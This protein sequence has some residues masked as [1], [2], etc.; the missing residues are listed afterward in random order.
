LLHPTGR[1]YVVNT[2]NMKP[3]LCEYLTAVNFVIAQCGG[4]ANVSA[5]PVAGLAHRVDTACPASRTTCLHSSRRS[6]TSARLAPLRP[7]GH[8]RAK[9]LR[10]TR[11]HGRAS[12]LARGRPR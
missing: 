12:V 1:G 4:A 10:L 8:C 9:D 5:R 7:S 3:D 11:V 6:L 2:G